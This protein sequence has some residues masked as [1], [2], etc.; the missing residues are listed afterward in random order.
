MIS[1]CVPTNRVGG[2]DLLCESLADSTY[3]DFELIISDALHGFRSLRVQQRLEQYDFR[4]VHV[5]PARNAFPLNQ[6]S[7]VANTALHEAR[8]DVILLAVDYTWFP[9]DLLAVHAEFHK[10]HP[11]QRGL[12]LPHNYFEMPELHPAFPKYGNE[13]TD[14]Y[15]RDV[16]GHSLDDVMWSI[17]KEPVVRGS[18]GFHVLDKTGYANVDPKLANIAS[19][20]V[21]DYP[22]YLHA[23]NESVPAESMR[24]ING[25]DERLD[26][27]H[28]YQDM[29]LAD[30][31]TVKTGLRWSIRES[32]VAQ[33]VNPRRVFPFPRRIRPVESNHNVW[34][35]AKRDGYP[36]VN[37]WEVMPQR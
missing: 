15:A 16:A 4:I 1:I 31:L 28:C 26:G 33:I 11:G 35:A 37:D 36:R 13:E 21:H 8:G 14:R 5:G 34:Q 3:K 10:T 12:M 29:D 30:R 7:H 22:S 6:F 24:Q 32:P 9:K 17:F 18:D 27:G 20:P 19:I 2:F 23:K 25:W